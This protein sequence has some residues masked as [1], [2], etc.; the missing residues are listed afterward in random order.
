MDLVNTPE[1]FWT[2]FCLGL[3]IGIALGFLTC[4]YALLG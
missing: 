3:G 2:G 1:D 4:A